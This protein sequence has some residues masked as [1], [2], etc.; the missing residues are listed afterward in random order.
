MALSIVIIVPPLRRKVSFYPPFG[1]LSIIAC[2]ET[3]GHKA[4][5]LDL[6]AHRCNYKKTIEQI[7][8]FSPD[9]IGISAVVATSYKYVKEISYLIKQNMP[10]A[11]I[12]VGGGLAAAGGTLLNNSAVD[13]LVEGEGEVTFKELLKRIENKESYENVAGIIF[14]RKNQIIKNPPRELIPDLDIL[15]FPDYGRL[16]LSKYILN[17]HEFLKDYGCPEKIDFRV[18]DANRNP[19]FL[20]IIISRGCVNRCTFCYRHMPGVRIHSLKYIGDLIEHVKTKYNLGH[21]SFGDECF[22]PTKRWLWSFIEML[23]QR[24]F[25]LTFHITG[26]RVNAVD[27]EIMKALKELGVWH[28]QFGFESGSQKILNI[29]EKHTTTKQNMEV[30]KLAGQVGIN[31]IPFIIIG[32]P[33]ETTETIYETLDFLKKIDLMSARFRP[34]FPMAM[35]G[36]PLFEYAKLKG[37]IS[38]EDKYLEAVSN[39]EA[40]NLSKNNYFINYTDSPTEVVMGWMALFR[41]E[42]IKHDKPELTANLIKRLI[43]AVNKYGIINTEKMAINKLVNKINADRIE[44]LYAEKNK[45]VLVEEN[46]SLRVDGIP[47]QGEGLRKVIERF[48]TKTVGAGIETR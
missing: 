39:V 9:V 20:R 4:H 6:D 1:A 45:P 24:K 27:L 3:E 16:D 19:N 40:E 37:Y 22:G 28:I 5:L 2:V 12:V 23:R 32:Y 42:S 7:A 34:T 14:K 46:D 30:V 21:I 15:P 11:I 17:I 25:D 33:G 48:K 41:N 36:T 8:K 10:N 18:T 43:R 29:M 35:P 47:L 31:T 13:V 44:R 38:D 26:M